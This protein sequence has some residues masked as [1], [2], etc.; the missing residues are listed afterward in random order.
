MGPPS[1]TGRPVVADAHVRLAPKEIGDTS[2]YPWHGFAEDPSSHGFE[3]HHR[4]R[5]SESRRCEPAVLDIN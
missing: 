3:T 2:F 5:R 4:E 1:G